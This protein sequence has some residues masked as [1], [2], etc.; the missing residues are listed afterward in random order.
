MLC[1]C[2]CVRVRVQGSVY[3]GVAYEGVGMGA[4]MCHWEW[5][6]GLSI[7]HFKSFVNLN[8]TESITIL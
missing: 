4:R 3:E 5:N 1:A 6:A 2:V 8:F 7:A